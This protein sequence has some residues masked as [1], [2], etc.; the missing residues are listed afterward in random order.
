MVKRLLVMFLLCCAAPALAGGLGDDGLHHEDWFA[1][2][3]LDLRDDAAEAATAGKHLLVVWEQKGCIYCKEWHEQHLANPAILATLKANFVVVQLNLRGDRPV[4]DL[5]GQELSEK[6]LARKSRAA[7][8]PTIH[9]LPRE[10]GDRKGKPL[11]EAEIARM[12]GLLKPEQFAAMLEYVSGRHYAQGLS[13]Q[14]WLAA[15]GS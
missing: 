5:D 13:F 11:A 2:S 10:L 9:F 14:K 15:R 3:L 7:T 8:T 1:T 6:E 4:T 12:P